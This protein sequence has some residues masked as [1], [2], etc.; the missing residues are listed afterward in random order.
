MY[1]CLSKEQTLLMPLALAQ[2]SNKA[3]TACKGRVEGASTSRISRSVVLNYTQPPVSF[4][5][6]IISSFT[7]SPRLQAST[8]PAPPSPLP[9][10]P[11][12]LVK[13]VGEPPP[14]PTTK[15]SDVINTLARSDTQTNR[16]PRERETTYSQ[17]L[18]FHG[19]SSQSHQNLSSRLRSARVAFYPS[20]RRWSRSGQDSIFRH[21]RCSARLCEQ[22]V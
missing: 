8:L 17:L 6:N 11:I 19:I 12:A 5:C 2:G 4:T 15:V 18:S 7:D 21:L 16:G 1:E 22:S 10:S 20:H 14:P 3:D 13:I 9:P